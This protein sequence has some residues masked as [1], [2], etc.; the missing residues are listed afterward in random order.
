MNSILTNT[1]WASH[2]YSLRHEKA[3]K[4]TE[5]SKQVWELKNDGNVPNPAWEI[6]DRAIPCKNGN[7]LAT[8]KK[9]TKN[10]I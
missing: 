9:K 3:S 8:L 2:N 1:R 4:S 6:T 5:L 7:K 10:I